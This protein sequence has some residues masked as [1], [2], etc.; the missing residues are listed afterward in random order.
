[1]SRFAAVLLSVMV[2]FLAK[3]ILA[4]TGGGWAEVNLV[5]ELEQGELTV[6]RAFETET[7]TAGPKPIKIYLS[8]TDSVHCHKGSLV[9]FYDIDRD[10]YITLGNTSFVARQFSKDVLSKTV[11]SRID[12]EYKIIGERMARERDNSPTVCWPRRGIKVSIQALCVIVGGTGQRNTRVTL[13]GNDLNEPYSFEQIGTRIDFPNDLVSQLIA[14][15][16]EGETGF[17]MMVRIGSGRRKNP[18]LELM[19]REDETALAQA[20][21]RAGNLHGLAGILSTANLIRTAE[22]WPLLADFY[23]ESFKK[24]GDERFLEQAAGAYE[25]IEAWGE[26]DRIRDMAISDLEN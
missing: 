25:M 2:L 9:S 1:M 12:E 11:L 14:L 7:I 6:F 13:T 20:L 23:L 4:Q 10:E 8:A 22:Q 15:H 21:E 26:A 19:S 18:R 5:I 16:D 3:D 24:Y 17:N